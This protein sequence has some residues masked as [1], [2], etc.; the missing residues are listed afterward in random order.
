MRAGVLVLLVLLTLGGCAEPTERDVVEDRRAQ[1]DIVREQLLVLAGR[2]PDSVPRNDCPR[3]IR[4]GGEPATIRRDD[5]AGSNALLMMAGELATLRDG[6]FASPFDFSLTG[7]GRADGAIVGETLYGALGLRGETVADTPAGT[8]G[9]DLALFDHLRYVI[10]VRPTAYVDPVPAFAFSPAA[11]NPDGT[12]VVP[13][14]R[15]SVKL[16]LLVMDLAAAE[17]RCAFTVAAVPDS[18]FGA[19]PNEPLAEAVNR[20]L[21]WQAWDAVQAALRNSACCDTVNPRH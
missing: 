20:H 7:R 12:P 21:A 13:P 8:L 15:G 9:D 19:G 11:K 6:G 16:D 18:A 1:L 4:P 3:P 17:L 5:A 10:V 14:E 2:L